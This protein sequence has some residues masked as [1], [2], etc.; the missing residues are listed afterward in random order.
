MVGEALDE[1]PVEVCEPE[2]GLDFT[3]SSGGWPLRNSSHFYRVHPHFSFGDNKS[4]VLN[5]RSFKLALLRSEVELVLSKLF[6][7]SPDY[8]L[9]LCQRLGEDQD[10]IQVHTV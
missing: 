8:P 6:H 2:E 1:A 10:V 9:V 3:F 4:E 7:Y 5:L